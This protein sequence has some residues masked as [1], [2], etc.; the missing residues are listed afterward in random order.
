[1]KTVIY[2]G[3]FNPITNGH[4]DL[5]E[6]ATRLFDRVIVA[7][8]ESP[9]KSPLFS[10]EERL[11][12]CEQSLSHLQGIEI[13]GF[14]GLMVDVARDKGACAVLRGVRGVVDYEYELQLHNM[15]RDMYPQFET[16]FL[17]PAEQLAH[18]SS[19]LVREIASLG[20]DVSSFVSAPAFKALQDKFP[21]KG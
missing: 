4:I 3:T 10:L 15:N 13:C 5:V 11:R 1:M 18:I 6:R 19:T 7:V 8:A 9:G 16:V 21:A 12:I 17:S 2:S 14:T 20:G